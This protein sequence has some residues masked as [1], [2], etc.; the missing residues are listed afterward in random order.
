MTTS[1]IV[2]NNDEAAQGFDRSSTVWG[3]GGAANKDATTNE[4]AGFAMA[5]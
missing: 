4:L 3:K 5:M 1:L 2:C